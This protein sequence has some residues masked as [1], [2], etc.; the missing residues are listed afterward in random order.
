VVA[1]A[2]RLVRSQRNVEQ[3]ASLVAPLETVIKETQNQDLSKRAQAALKQ[4]QAKIA[5]PNR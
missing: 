1:I 5:A 3:A 4:A 2:E